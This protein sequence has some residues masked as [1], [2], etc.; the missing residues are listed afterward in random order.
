MNSIR[1]GSAGD[2]LVSDAEQQSE[3]G[4]PNFRIADYTG[5][6]QTSFKSGRGEGMTTSDIYLKLCGWEVR[7]EGS[8][9]S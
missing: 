7:D 3:S 6:G 2:R 1:T 9:A 4:I 5:V 8:G